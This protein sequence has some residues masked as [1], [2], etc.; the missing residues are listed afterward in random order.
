MSRTMQKWV[1]N[2]MLQKQLRASLPIQAEIAILA[3]LSAN[4]TTKPFVTL[5]STAE[6]LQHNTNCFP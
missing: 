5:Q 1:S 3:I 6:V 4:K 2:H